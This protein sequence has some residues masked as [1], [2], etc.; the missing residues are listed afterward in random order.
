LIGQ[1]LAQRPTAIYTFDPRADE[2][3]STFFPPKVKATGFTKAFR[4]R[5]QRPRLDTIDAVVEYHS[6]AMDVDPSAP[7]PPGVGWHEVDADTLESAWLGS[8]RDKGW[9]RPLIERAGQAADLVAALARDA[10]ACANPL[11]KALFQ[12]DLL[13]MAMILQDAIEAEPS[14]QDRAGA[15][16]TLKWLLSLWQRHWLTARELEQMTALRPKSIPARRYRA[17]HQFDLTQDYLPARVLGEADGWYAMPYGDKP[18]VHYR[19]FAGRSFISIYMKPPGWARDEFYRYW[20]TVADKFGANVTRDG[21]VPPLPAGTETLLLRTFAVFLDDGTCADS[22]FP[23]EVL[24]RLIKYRDTQ[25]DLATSDYRGTLHYRYVM[26]RRALLADAG[27][28][29]LER[30]RDEDPQFFGFLSEVPDYRRSSSANLTTMRTNCVSCH[31][32]ALYSASTMFSL[33]YQRRGREGRTKVEGGLLQPATAPGRFH[34]H[35]REYTAMRPFLN[36]EPAR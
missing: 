33:G 4:D 11:E 2:L 35:S 27:S 13:Q 28:L 22:G 10:R 31:S 24:M 17:T 7:A 8:P 21:R 30:V 32:E 26:R 1:P 5:A 3:R 20:D 9:Q 16:N 34:L 6:Q 18:S 15:Q 14:A 23:E 19:A 36:H 29:G 12:R 25:L